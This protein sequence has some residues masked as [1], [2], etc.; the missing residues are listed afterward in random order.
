MQSATSTVPQGGLTTPL[1]QIVL[2][3][4][5]KATYDAIYAVMSLSRP[6]ILHDFACIFFDRSFMCES[7]FSRL[8]MEM[9][10]SGRMVCGVACV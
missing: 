2:Q 9:H 6:P 8:A 5:M 10:V 1:N 7:S 4:P 3:V